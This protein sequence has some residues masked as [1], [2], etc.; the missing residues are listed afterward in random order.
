MTMTNPIRV[1]DKDGVH[2][3]SFCDENNDLICLVLS[4][5]LVPLGNMLDMITDAV[6]DAPVQLFINSS[7]WNIEEWY[8]WSAFELSPVIEIFKANEV[9]GIGDEIRTEWAWRRVKP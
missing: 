8:T 5:H 1:E 7:D 6:P 9:Y 2:H 3:Y 4:E